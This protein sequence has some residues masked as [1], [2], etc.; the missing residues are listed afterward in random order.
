M[1]DREG[2]ASLAGLPKQLIEN[3]GQAGRGQGDDDVLSSVLKG[4]RLSGSLQFCFMPAG[5]WHTDDKPAFSGGG[6][7]V[8]PFHI[9][10][11]GSCWLKVQGRHLDLAPGDIVAFPFATGH[12]LGH[13]SGGS[14]INPRRRFHPS[15]GARLRS[16]GT[17]GAHRDSG[18]FAATCSAMPWTSGRCARRCRC[19]SI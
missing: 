3:P 10:V 4:I 2:T 14:M 13:G 19:C 5:D 6:A 16:C 1:Y 9:L 15:H 12:Q 17:A 18:C 11:E 7:G 8:M